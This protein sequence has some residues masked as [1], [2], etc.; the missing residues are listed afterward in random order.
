LPIIIFLINKEIGEKVL[1]CSE[2]NIPETLKLDMHKKA[3]RR[4]G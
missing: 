1:P 3:R 2:R 4:A